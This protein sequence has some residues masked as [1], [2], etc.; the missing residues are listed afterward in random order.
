MRPIQ[1]LADAAIPV[2]I[3]V[4]GMQLERAKVLEKPRVVASAAALSL[5]AAPLVSIALTWMLGLTG[6]ARQAGVALASMPTAVITTI[7]ALEFGIAPVFVTN[8]VFI[9]TLLSPLTLA[10][11]I[12]YLMRG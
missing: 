9:T 7:L 2:M 4:L 12:A 6:P 5:V 1:L 11:L 8:V 10:P 3:L